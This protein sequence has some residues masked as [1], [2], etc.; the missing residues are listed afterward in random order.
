MKKTKISL[1]LI[2]GVML[3]SGC[4][5]PYSGDMD[6][7]NVT[8]RL[9]GSSAARSTWTGTAPTDAFLNTYVTHVVHLLS[10]GNHVGGSPISIP[11]S[12]GR[13]ITRNV[14]LGPLVVNV[15]ATVNGFGFAHG[16]GG[17]NVV[18]GSNN[19]VPITMQRLDYGIVLRGFSRDSAGVYQF[20]PRL[21]DYST[22][23][24]PELNIHIY[25][26]AE[27]PTGPLTVEI[28][29]DFNSA[30]TSITSI[31]SDGSNNTLVVRPNHGL[32]EGT[33][34]GTVRVHGGR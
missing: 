31:A 22:T 26:F 1:A 8:I 27:N 28:T 14:P 18:T 16:T 21:P 32:G 4:L 7:G 12:G 5:S 33:H 19:E 13:E 24:T 23:S 25:N 20:S 34:T 9:P 10:N 3:L 17:T 15:F 29:G 2:L 30:T 11:P 6:T